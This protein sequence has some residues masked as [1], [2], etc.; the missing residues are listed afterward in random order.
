MTEAPVGIIT[1]ISN[2]DYHAGP[3]LSRSTVWTAYTKTPAHTRLIEPSEQDS[4]ALAKG[5][6]LD[7]ALLDPLA[8]ET[9]VMRGPADRRGNKWIEAQAEAHNTGRILLTE[10]GYKE[11]EMMREIA[12][13]HPTI[14]PIVTRDDGVRGASGYAVHQDTGLLRKARPDLWI[15]TAGLMID[16]KTSRDASPRGFSK[17]IGEYGYHVQEEW[18]REVWQEAGGGEVEAFLFFVVESA[19]PYQIAVYE[20]DEPARDKARGVIRQMLPIMQACAATGFYPGYP[21][22]VQSIGLPAWMMRGE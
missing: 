2:E 21:S 7:I 13:H 8:F 18:Y 6:A 9:K 22:G 3:G 12:I 15:P 14:G 19:D 17:S 16:L 11:V 1:G 5:S 10:S 20:I 4:N